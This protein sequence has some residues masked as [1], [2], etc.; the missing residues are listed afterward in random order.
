[1]VLLYRM[2]VCD[3]T[4]NVAAQGELYKGREKE[5]GVSHRMEAGRI[6]VNGIS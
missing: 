2:L 5:G 3:G 6:T 4:G 1:M